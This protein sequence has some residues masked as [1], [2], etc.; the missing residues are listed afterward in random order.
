M[1]L[2]LLLVVFCFRR[3]RRALRGAGADGVGVGAGD[4][5]PPGVQ[6]EVQAV[7]GGADSDKVR[8]ELPSANGLASCERGPQA[9]VDYEVFD[10]EGRDEASGNSQARPAVHSSSTGE[11]SSWFVAIPKRGGWD[12]KTAR[13]LEAGSWKQKKTHEGRHPL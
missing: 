12:R 10:H 7:Q 3:V 6:R 2:L 4:H 9:R 1:L 13:G 8:K 11:T 5:V